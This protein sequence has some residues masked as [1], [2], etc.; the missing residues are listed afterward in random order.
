ME[1]RLYPNPTRPG[2]GLRPKRERRRTPYHVTIGYA[3]ARTR[4]A[5]LIGFVSADKKRKLAVACS[6]EF[7]GKKLP[8][9]REE[10]ISRIELMGAHVI[11]AT[12]K[13]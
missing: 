6:D 12:A 2:V 1:V 9:L 8:A 11:P 10:T 3:E 7:P 4:F 13:L 5:S